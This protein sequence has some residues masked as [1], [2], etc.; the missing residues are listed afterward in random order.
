MAPLLGDSYHA[1]RGSLMVVQDTTVAM[2]MSQGSSSE[3]LKQFDTSRA[4][5]TC[6]PTV[7]TQRNRLDAA[8]LPSQTRLVPA[9]TIATIFAGSGTEEHWSI[10]R[11]QTKAQGW[12][13]FSDALLA[14]DA[15]NALVRQLGPD[16]VDVGTTSVPSGA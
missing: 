2:H 16:R 8:L 9:S 14:G 4:S 10:F 3:W 5:A 6:E 12:L 15:L 11:T 1:V 7:T 13:A